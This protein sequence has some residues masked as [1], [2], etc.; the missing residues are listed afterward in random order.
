MNTALAHFNK[1]EKL[2]VNPRR[3]ISI[4]LNYSLIAP[5]YKYRMIE[6]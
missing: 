5:V 4:A 1:T 6:L 2:K 3:K